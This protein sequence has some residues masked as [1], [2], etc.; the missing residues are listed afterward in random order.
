[1]SDDNK[2]GRRSQDWFGGKGPKGSRPPRLVRSR[3]V[4]GDH[5]DGRPVIGI[6]NTWSELTPCN[7]HFGDLAQ[8]VPR[9]HTGSGR[10]VPMEFLVTSPGETLTRPTAMLLRNLTSMDVEETLRANPDRRRRAAGCG[11]DK[12]TPALMMGAA[13]VNLL[14]IGLVVGA[15]AERQLAG[16]VGYGIKDAWKLGDDAARGARHD[17]RCRGVRKPPQ[18][19]RTAS[20]T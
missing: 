17:R 1:M 20:A 16:Q 7:S 9:G 5:F 19:A 12:T 8:Y 3:G 2:P 18:P 13:S 14:T 10:R 4:P 6:C 15:H 11:C